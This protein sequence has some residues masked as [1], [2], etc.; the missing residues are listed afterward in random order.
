M[1]TL[2]Q[3]AVNILFGALAHVALI[4][5]IVVGALVATDNIDQAI[6]GAVGL[7]QLADNL[8]ALL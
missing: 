2:V 1:N 8:K 3:A 5:L 4:P 7:L 6:N